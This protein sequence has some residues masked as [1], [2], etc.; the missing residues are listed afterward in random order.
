M[1]VLGVPAAK[2]H[3]NIKGNDNDNELQGFI[4][5][6]EAVISNRVGPLLAVTVTRQVRGGGT[7][8][9]LPVRPAISLASVTPLGST[10]LTLSDLSLDKGIVTY[11]TH[12]VFWAPR[13]TVVY[14]AGWQVGTDPEA[15]GYVALPADLLLADKELVRHLWATQRGGASRPGSKPSEALA[16]TLPGSAYTLPNR[17]EQLLAPHTRAG[18]F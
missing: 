3:L 1:S 5:A 10:A 18:F 8:L 6:A 7:A 4:D 11:V 15:E 17:V 2:S 14:Q 12:Q 13:Y 16:N 9:I